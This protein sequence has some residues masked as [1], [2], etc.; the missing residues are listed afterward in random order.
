MKLYMVWA[1]YKEHYNSAMT[2]LIGRTFI[3]FNENE[4]NEALPK[5]LKYMYWAVIWI[6]RSY[7]VARAGRARNEKWLIEIWTITFTPKKL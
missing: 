3:S 2:T 4:Y 7:G 6:N 1:Q 5:G